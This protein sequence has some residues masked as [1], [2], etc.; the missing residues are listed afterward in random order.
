VFKGRFVIRYGDH[1]E[2]VSAGDA[3]YMA[4]GHVPAFLEDTEMFEL[5]PA[6]E[7][8]A[9][10]DVVNANAACLDEQLWAQR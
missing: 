4:P 9:V 7:L 1:E 2:T 5:S 3:F 6:D 10:L 8:K